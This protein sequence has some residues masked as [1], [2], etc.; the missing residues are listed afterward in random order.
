MTYDQFWNQDV[1]LVKAYQEADKI[2]RDLRNQDMWIQGA[3]I[4]EAILDAAPALRFS[5]SKKPPKPI[6][7]CDQPID[8]HVGGRKQ[9]GKQEKPLSAEEKSDKKAKAMMEMFMV[10]INKKFDGKGGDRNG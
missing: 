6:P 1:C 4:Y 2:K 7:Y 3:Y 5:F 8:I 9:E 10:S